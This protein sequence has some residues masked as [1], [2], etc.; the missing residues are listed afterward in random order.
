MSDVFYYNQHDKIGEYCQILDAIQEAVAH[1]NTE[2]INKIITDKGRGSTKFDYYLS[3]IADSIY[4]MAST[5]SSLLPIPGLHWLAK[6]AVTMTTG[7]IASKLSAKSSLMLHS[8]PLHEAV[9]KEKISLKEAKNA[10]QI[11]G[12]I[13]GQAKK[14]GKEIL[15]EPDNDPKAAGLKKNKSKM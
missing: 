7:T 4:V 2:E 1:G 12:T 10:N 6:E 9:E 5:A 8:N 3:V 14:R 11:Y 15:R 13:L